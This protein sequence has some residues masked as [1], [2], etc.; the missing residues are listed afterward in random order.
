VAQAGLVMAT[1]MSHHAQTWIPTSSHLF[2]MIFVEGHCSYVFHPPASLAR[3]VES[4]KYTLL[5][6]SSENALRGESVQCQHILVWTYRRS[7]N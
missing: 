1:F 5:A 3:N 6:R 7:S 2:K 4:I